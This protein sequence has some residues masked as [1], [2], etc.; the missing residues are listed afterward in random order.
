MTDDI[1]G[2]IKKTMSVNIMFAWMPIPAPYKRGP[3]RE[4]GNNG[5]PAIGNT[6]D[7]D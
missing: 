3:L 4:E 6:G 7:A 1:L 2:Q 5:T